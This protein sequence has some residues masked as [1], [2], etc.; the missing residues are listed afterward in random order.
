MSSFTFSTSRK[1]LPDITPDFC[2]KPVKSITVY[3]NVRISLREERPDWS[4]L[5]TFFCAVLR[6]TDILLHLRQNHLLLPILSPRWELHAVWITLV[7]TPTCLS[8]DQIQWF[9]NTLVKAFHG[10][11]VSIL[12]Y[13][14]WPSKKTAF[15]A[16]AGLVP[17]I[18]QILSAFVSHMLTVSK[19]LSDQLFWRLKSS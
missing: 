6:I 13:Q 8:T 15:S 2:I 5:W 7:N 10:S 1:T 12:L 3:T 19:Y 17:S 16:V 9:T 14:G 11:D 4:L 18:I